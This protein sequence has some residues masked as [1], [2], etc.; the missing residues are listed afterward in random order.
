MFWEFNHFLVFEVHRRQDLLERSALGPR[1]VSLSEFETSYTGIVLT[2]TPNEEF[3]QEGQVPSLANRPATIVRKP[4]GALFILLSGL[5]L[6]L[7][8]LVIPI[9]SQILDEVIGNGM[10]N[11]LKPMLW[12]MALTMTCRLL[13]Y[14]LLGT[15]TLER[16]LTRRFAVSFE[17]QMLAFPSVFTASGMDQALP[18]AWSRTPASLSS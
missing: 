8:Q 4:G 10:E 14:Q 5:M 7:P 9:F 11:W 6:I 16:R 15:R 1:K 2:L 18:V 12:A 17:H 13:Q 3:V